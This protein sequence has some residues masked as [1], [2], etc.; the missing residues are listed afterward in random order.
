MLRSLVGSEMCIRDRSTIAVKL[1]VEEFH[2]S[3]SMRIKE[4][5]NDLKDKVMHLILDFR[6]A[7]IA[8]QLET[9]KNELKNE[10]N[11]QRIKEIMDK[12]KQL[13]EVY[14]ILAQ[15]LGNDIIV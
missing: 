2:L 7:Y 5:E 10:S 8:E 4:K 9:L 6:K 13:K 11:Y 12:Y 3:K 14:D 15:K 1:S